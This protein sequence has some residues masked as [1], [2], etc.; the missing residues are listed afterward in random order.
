MAKQTPTKAASK[1]EGDII[2]RCIQR[3]ED[4]KAV[5]LPKDLRDEVDDTRPYVREAA[6]R[7][8]EKI[9]ESDSLGLARSALAALDAIASDENSTRHVAEEAARVLDAHPPSEL[10]SRCGQEALATAEPLAGAETEQHAVIAV[11]SQPVAEVVPLGR[12]AEVPRQRSTSAVVRHEEKAVSTAASEAGALSRR[13]GAGRRAL[14]LVEGAGIAAVILGIGILL[15]LAIV[16]PWHVAMAQRHPEFL[17]YYVVVQHFDLLASD[18]R[19]RRVVA[20]HR[21]HRY[22]VAHQ[23]IE[24][25]QA[26]PYGAIPE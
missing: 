24:F 12:A 11:T 23:S 17:H 10:M 1:V 5:L 21:D 20:N 18:L 14:W 19:P 9:L 4:I 13:A 2:L 6:V 8:L 7:K 25:T 22:I 3:L 15:F 26:V 16:L